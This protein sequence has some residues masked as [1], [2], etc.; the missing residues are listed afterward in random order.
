MHMSSGRIVLDGSTEQ[1]FGLGQPAQLHVQH[2][3][4]V[5]G[6]GIPGACFESRP[7]FRL[8]LGI[9]LCLGIRCAE[10]VASPCERGV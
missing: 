4:V 3:K 8:G 5:A 6:R 2:A 1:G 9:P 7:Q 10:F